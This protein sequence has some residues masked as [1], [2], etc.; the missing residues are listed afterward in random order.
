MKNAALKIVNRIGLLGELVKFS[1]TLFA[2]PFALAG[3]FLAARPW[4]TWSQF[5]WIL[6]AMAGARTGA[7]GFNR[8]ADFKLDADNP[9]TAGRPLPSSRVGRAE[10]AVLVAASFGLLAYASWRLNPLCFA[11]SPLAAGWVCLYSYT[12][13]FTWASHFFLGASLGLAPLGAWIAVRGSFSWVPVAMG[14]AVLLWVAGF[15]ILYALQDVEFDRSRGLFSIPASFGVR[16][17]L[18][19]SRLLHILTVA[20]LLAITGK[21]GMGWPY[22][23]GVALG[24]LLLAVEHSL[25]SEDDLSRLNTAF[26]NVNSLF[27]FLVLLAVV[28]GKVRP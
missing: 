21:E 7:M 28:A 17:A 6:V 12:K 18:T 10:V 23:A 1:H 25:V 26:F 3:A 13:R 24:G 27:S 2:L 11:L 20:A 16:R 19:V 15:D 8:L 22:V 9:R 14:C 5:G 4:P